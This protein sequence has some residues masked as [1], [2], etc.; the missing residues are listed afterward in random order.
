MNNRKLLKYIG[1]NQGAAHLI[2]MGE[3]ITNSL[4]VKSIHNIEI[5]YSTNSLW[6]VGDKE[7]N[8]VYHDDSWEIIDTLDSMDSMDTIDSVNPYDYCI[9]DDEVLS[10]EPE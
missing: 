5:L 9:D 8:W 2:I 10:W 4:S 7:D 1:M 3:I 6:V